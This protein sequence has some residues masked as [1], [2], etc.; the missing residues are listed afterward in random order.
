MLV[1][2]EPVG[3]GDQHQALGR[4]RACEQA[5]ELLLVETYLGQRRDGLAA[6]H[7]PDHDLLAVYAGKRAHAS[8][9]RDGVRDQPRA[10]VLRQATLGDVEAGDDLH[11][12]NQCRCS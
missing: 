6:G 11:S 1:L 9:D 10:T 8:I 4:E 5:L 3:A 7:Q 2:P 12:A